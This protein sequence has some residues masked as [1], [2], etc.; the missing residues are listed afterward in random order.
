VPSRTRPVVFVDADD[1]LWENARYFEEVIDGFEQLMADLGIPADDAHAA[2]ERCEERNIPLTGYGAAPF[3]ASVR[4]AAQGLCP[5]VGPGGAARI[6]GF[7]RD[8]E[9]RIRDH[10]IR[11]LPGVA[12]GVARLAAA[13]ELVVLTKGRPGEQT[14]KVER[15]GLSAHFT[16]VLVVPEKTNAVYR[17]AC[18]QQRVAPSV[19]WMVG[20][21]PR[22]DVNPAR[23]AGLRTVL[24]A[25]DAPWHREV[26]PLEQAGIATIHA[27]DFAAAAD[28]ILAAGRGC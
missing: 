14:S 11:L 22:S 5:S 13:R 20:N 18:A 25:H 26:E 21:S 8:A 3:A 17:D 9:R 12:D 4:E 1:T 15:S 16:D 23:R 7:A 24:V 28:A 19:T 27:A 10:A 2:L 6:A